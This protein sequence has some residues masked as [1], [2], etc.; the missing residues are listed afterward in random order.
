MIKELEIR[1][2][3]RKLGVPE[4][5]IE[6]DYAQNWLLINLSKKLPIA[7]KGGTGIRKVYIKDYR[8]SDDLDFTML[9]NIRGVVVENAIIEAIQ[10]AKRESGIKF[11][12]DMKF[13]EVKNGFTASIYFK[14]IK[15]ASSPLKI[16]IDL[17][18]KE[19]EVLIFPLKRKKINHPYSDECNDK[20]QIY[21]LE[22]IF[23]EK[24]R[25]IFQRTR[26]RDLYDVWQLSKQGLE[27][28]N[29]V[30]EKFEFKNV[31]IDYH[32]ISRRKEDFKNAWE[33]SLVHQLKI[34]PDFEKTYN[35][36]LQFLITLLE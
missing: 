8:F 5:T 27:I 12:E 18:K 25:A 17:T 28:S 29:K 9:D 30:H 7:L 6:R 23:S 24:I 4:T 26:P 20:I 36:V 15:R 3:A 14:I 22:E 13:R 11:N 10:M 19:N 1:K 31:K 35:R 2:T 34:L 16:K 33:K 32:D 21:S